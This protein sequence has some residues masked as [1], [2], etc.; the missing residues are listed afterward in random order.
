MMCCRARE[1][2]GRIPVLVTG[3]R[4]SH[5]P[6]GAEQGVIEVLGA[7]NAGGRRQRCVRSQCDEPCRLGFLCLITITAKRRLRAVRGVEAKGT[8]PRDSWTARPWRTARGFGPPVGRHC[9]DVYLSTAIHLIGLGRDQRTSRTWIAVAI[10]VLLL[11]L[12]PDG[13]PG[14]ARAAAPSGSLS[15][16]YTAEALD[17]DNPSDG[18]NDFLL[19]NVTVDVTAGGEFLLIAQL[20]PSVSNGLWLLLRPG[21]HAATVPIDGRRIREAGQDGPYSVNLILETNCRQGCI[22]LDQDAFSTGP[23]RAAD[24][25]GPYAAFAGPPADVA[26]DTDSPPD[27]LYDVFAVLVPVAVSEPGEYVLWVDSMWTGRMQTRARLPIGT[28]IVAVSTPGWV[29]RQSGV[30]G[31]SSMFLIVWL[32]NPALQA[33]SL[34]TSFATQPYDASEFQATPASVI[35]GGRDMGVD[36]D[37]PPDGRYDVLAVDLP[38]QVNRSGDFRIQ[39]YLQTLSGTSLDTQARVEYLP[40][41]PQNIEVRFRT[42]TI[43]DGS[44]DGPYRVLYTFQDAA[45]RTLGSGQYTTGSY[46]ALDFDAPL[47]AWNGAV[48]DV[49]ED[50]DAPADGVYDRYVVRVPVTVGEAGTYGFLGVFDGPEGQIMA[51]NLSTLPAGPTVVNL[52]WSAG[53]FTAQGIVPSGSPWIAAYLS[54]FEPILSQNF[55]PSPPPGSS[56]LAPPLVSVS[57]EPQTL[58]PD[59]D[60]DGLYDSLDFVLP[61]TATRAGPYSFSAML[62]SV[63][64]NL[65]VSFAT[66]HEFLAAGS[67]TVRLSFPG[68]AIRASGLSGPYTVFVRVH[69]GALDPDPVFFDL[70]SQ[71]FYAYTPPLLSHAF[72]DRSL[73]RSVVAGARPV[74]DG[75]LDPAEWPSA[76]TIEL[77]SSDPG[78]LE[79]RALLAND[80]ES[81]Y[82]VL[83]VPG[84]KT[85]GTTD[86]ASLAFDVLT[87]DSPDVG[88]ELQVGVGFTFRIPEREFRLDFEF[89][90]FYDGWFLRQAPFDAATPER[91]NLTAAIGFGPSP[92]DATPHRIYEFQVPLS[93]LGATPGETI[94]FAVYSEYTRGIRDGSGRIHGWPVGQL[95]LETVPLNNFVHLRLASVTN[96]RPS[97]AIR[98]PSAGSFG[99]GI[100]TAEG[101][102]SDSDGD[103]V[104]VEMRIDSGPWQT[105]AGTTTWNLTFDSR[106]YA[107][108]PHTICARAFDG[109]A[110]S[111]EF[112]VAV[113]FDNTAPTLTVLAP[114]EDTILHEG[115]IEV[116]WTVGDSGAGLARL[117]LILD[118]RAPITLTSADLASTSSYRFTNLADGAHSVKAVAYDNVGNSRTVVVTV[119]IDTNPLSPSGPYG[120]APLGGLLGG[121]VAVVA[122]TIL[123]IRRRR[124][125]KAPGPGPPVS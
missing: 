4:A 10:L 66:N 96:I 92:V 28:W 124:Q 8:L 45:F 35:P 106:T 53:A 11:L 105:A 94:G 80:N 69:D 63:Y 1:S 83:D 98:I 46:L 110:Y 27:G 44:F 60:G 82:V 24:F 19:V 13:L 76:G 120:L 104:R 5:P 86:A 15:P 84:D 22:V 48:Q 97:A 14:S 58:L 31:R 57:G 85:E 40:T 20:L 121:V 50:I 73:Y 37:A 52:T 17:Y 70:V 7:R 34:S 67:G 99:G 2:R 64:N 100:L 68:W 122:I 107:D 36:T 79:S 115:G 117:E 77:G 87:P 25:E 55:V 75:V 59:L 61:V 49:Y 3:G 74:V 47:L 119:R 43:A 42:Q 91:A 123:M 112:C 26:L 29:L 38:I 62:L 93:L 88:R 118:N 71:R 90:A 78:G 103:V 39:A 18:F 9:S 65:R 125:P 89:V 51:S 111:N 6:R 102:A 95:G 21:S 30:D 33:G 23:F 41:G 109:D 56:R 54:G 16:P 108:G 114:V 113:T 72:E 32:S 116:R 81:L 101:I 12:P